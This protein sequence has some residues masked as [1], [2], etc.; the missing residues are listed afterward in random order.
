MFDIFPENLQPRI[1]PIWPWPVVAAVSAVLLVIVLRSYPR[2]IA[3]LSRGD[4]VLAVGAADG[5]GAAA[6]LGDV[7]PSLV[8]TETDEQRRAVGHRHENSRSL[9]LAD[10]PGGL[11]R[12]ETILKTLADNQDLLEKIKEKVEVVHYEFNSEITQVEQPSSPPMGK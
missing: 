9:D 3:H 10:G 8:L 11:T 4:A 7:P 5:G 2:R 1:E 12:W 6:D